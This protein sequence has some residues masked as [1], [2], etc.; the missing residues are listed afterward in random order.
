MASTLKESDTPPHGCGDSE[1]GPLCFMDLDGT[2]PVRTCSYYKQATAAHIVAQ[3]CCDQV[4]AG[5]RTEC[6]RVPCAAISK[7]SAKP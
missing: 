6:D 2:C 4:R 7:K 5:T 3:T 1:D